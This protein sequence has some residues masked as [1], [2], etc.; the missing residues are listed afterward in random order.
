M[1]TGDLKKKLKE[2]QKLRKQKKYNEA[3]A[4]LD[5]I[6]NEESNIETGVAAYA[7]YQKGLILGSLNKIEEAKVSFKKAISFSQSK[8]QRKIIESGDFKVRKMYLDAYF[9]LK[10]LGEEKGTESSGMTKVLIDELLKN[11][12]LKIA[13]NIIE[14]F[15]NENYSSELKLAL[16]K[17]VEKNPDDLYLWSVIGKFYIHGQEYKKALD[18]YKKGCGSPIKKFESILGIIHCHVLFENY[19]KAKEY[20]DT[21][22][23]IAIS[24]KDIK[25]IERFEK[26]VDLALKNTKTQTAIKSKEPSS[27]EFTILHSTDPDLMKTVPPPPPEDEISKIEKKDIDSTETKTITKKSSIKQ[28][29]RRRRRKSPPQDKILSKKKP[30]NQSS[31]I[32]KNIEQ[33]EIKFIEHDKIEDIKTVTSI[34]HKSKYRYRTQRELRKSKKIKTVV[35][36]SVLIFILVSLFLLG[37]YGS[38]YLIEFLKI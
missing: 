34:S 23:K 25:N 11:T 2:V 29:A 35:I 1:L 7:Y 22:K 26:T 36:S 3:L 5:N 18:A 27:S 21:A 37:L 8:S 33:Q 15:N 28:P 20:I 24:D 32:E 12:D 14:K 13:L 31:D 17:L 19:N 30:V 38:K 4:L 6:D 16:E 9:L 10:K